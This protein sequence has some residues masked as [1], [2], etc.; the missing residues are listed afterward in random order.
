MRV[1]DVAAFVLAMD[2]TAFGPNAPRLGGEVAY[3]LQTWDGLGETL[4]T[5]R[6]V[7]VGELL[8]SEAPL[9]IAAR[10]LPEA[11]VGLF[12]E[13]AEANF[14]LA[15]VQV[16]YAFA[17]APSHDRELLLRKCCGH[18]ACSEPEHSIIQSSRHAAE[19]CSKHDPACA[20][21]PLDDLERAIVVFELNGFGQLA[22]GLTDG[23]TAIYPLGSKFSHQCLRPNCSF[24][25]RDGCINFR[26]GRDI[27]R[28]EV[29]TICY[30]GI[31]AHS[32]VHRRRSLLHR[33][34]G[35]FCSCQDCRGPDVLRA[36]PCLRC[37][38]RSVSGLI[39][40]SSEESV[41]APVKFVG[42]FHAEMIRTPCEQSIPENTSSSALWSCRWC[43][44]CVTDDDM[45]VVCR[46]PTQ[47]EWAVGTWP[48]H[49]ADGRLFEWE[50]ALEEAMHS[51]MHSLLLS[52]SGDASDPRLAT[53]DKSRPPTSHPS[54]RKLSVLQMAAEA[55]VGR[56]HWVPLMLGALRVDQWLQLAIRHAPLD[57]DKRSVSF[58]ASTAI[59]EASRESASVALQTAQKE[60]LAAIQQE[61]GTR[62]E[63]VSTLLSEI[64]AFLEGGHMR[65]CKAGLSLQ[66][67]DM[68]T[69][70]ATMIIAWAPVVFVTMDAVNKLMQQLTELSQRAAIEFG[71]ASDEVHCINDL[72]AAL[73]PIAIARS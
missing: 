19:W 52:Q 73:S 68:L 2:G 9:L 12:E 31:W 51:L 63:S 64:C 10:E 38:P 70:C 41:H 29:L 40:P 46:T 37:A 54:L 56:N 4:V 24:H 1:S 7:Q 55:V 47:D 39:V 16:A 32:S 11:L 67:W 23:A 53:S 21:I 59:G 22:D 45:N 36:M 50:A 60:L 49:L 15:D 66:S 25:G 3:E 20:V 30:L 71:S 34:K 14:V 43:G 28:G 65:D 6:A 13:E 58:R 44:C 33:H 61:S 5:T 18:E 42:S 8:L 69:D 62:F 35:F 17:R 57:Q 27:A 48:L 72:V 26:A